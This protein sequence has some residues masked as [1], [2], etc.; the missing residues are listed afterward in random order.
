MVIKAIVAKGL[1]PEVVANPA[2]FTSFIGGV[3]EHVTVDSSLTDQTIRDLALSLRL[4]RVR[5][6]AAAGP[7]LRLRHLARTASRSTS[8]TRRSWPRWARR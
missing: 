3:A 6:H 8:W 5:H 2:A 4:T 1:S 7:D